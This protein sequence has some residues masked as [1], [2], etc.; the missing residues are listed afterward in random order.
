MKTMLKL[1][2][3]ALMVASTS[4]KSFHT[5]E[6][7]DNVKKIANKTAEFCQQNRKIILAS[8]GTV[9]AVI[10][11]IKGHRRY[12]GDNLLYNWLIF[13]KAPVRCYD[14]CPL[15][16]N[17][18]KSFEQRAKDP[19]YNANNELVNAIIAKDINAIDTA[20]SH[21][22][23]VN[24]NVWDYNLNLTR[25]VRGRASQ[26]IFTAAVTTTGGLRESEKGQRIIRR[27]VDHGAIPSFLT[28]F[29]AQD[30]Q[31]TKGTTLIHFTCFSP[32]TR[33][34]IIE[35]TGDVPF[36]DVT[37][38]GWPIQPGHNIKYTWLGKVARVTDAGNEVYSLT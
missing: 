14:P 25:E 36:R 11:C 19:R 9:A 23:D 24:S 4:S 21:G 6:L 18:E 26:V 29:A 34:Y 2:I 38:P 33:K 3:M 22:A 20:F 32:E 5:D 7:V 37:E 30:D 1:A 17:Y 27:L 31:C 16:D 8:L 10:L 35:K 12:K 13:P 15:D 28:Y